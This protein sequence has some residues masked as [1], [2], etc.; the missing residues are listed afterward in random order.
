[1]PQK[2]KMFD[3]LNYSILLKTILLACF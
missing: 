3:Y 2:P 1:M